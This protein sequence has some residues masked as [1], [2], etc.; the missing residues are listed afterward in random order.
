MKKIILFSIF[1]ISIAGCSVTRAPSDYQLD[2][3]SGL[4]PP[5]KEKETEKLKDNLSVLKAGRNPLPTDDKA[6]IYTPALVEQVYIY[7]QKLSDDSFLAGT[8]MWLVVDKGDWYTSTDNGWGKL[9]DTKSL[10]N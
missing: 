4:V 2:I 5:N 3:K 6:P 10:N 9:L 1:S 7:P 8:W